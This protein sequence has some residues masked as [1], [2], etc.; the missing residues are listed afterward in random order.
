MQSLCDRINRVYSDSLF[1]DSQKPVAVVGET[2][3]TLSYCCGREIVDLT[4]V[5]VCTQERQKQKSGVNS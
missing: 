4:G 5:R 3:S 1:G 2:E